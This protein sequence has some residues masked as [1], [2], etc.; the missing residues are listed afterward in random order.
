MQFRHV[1]ARGDLEAQE[2]MGFLV[3]IL[4]GSSVGNVAAY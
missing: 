4:Y 1:A 3:E 2:E